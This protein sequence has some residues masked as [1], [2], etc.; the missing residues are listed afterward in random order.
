MFRNLYKK[1]FGDISSKTVKQ[2]QKVVQQINDLE[3]EMQRLPD[4]EFSRRTAAFK[5]QIRAATEDAKA[6]L[7]ELR[8]EWEREID[9]TTRA[10]MAQQISRQDKAIRE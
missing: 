2:A 10:Q 4:E 5:T 7:V 6:E 8:K 3:Q 1:A 9:T